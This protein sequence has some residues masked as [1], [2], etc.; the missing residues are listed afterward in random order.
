MKRSN[1]ALLSHVLVGFAALSF[2]FS[3]FLKGFFL[4]GIWLIVPLSAYIFWAIRDFRSGINLMLILL[5]AYCIIGGIREQNPWLLALTMIAAVSAWNIGG[6]TE[7]LKP[8]ETISHEA[9]LVRN[10][11]LLNGI[12]G[13]L[14]LLALLIS[15][16]I[17]LTLNIWVALILAGFIAFGLITT[18]RYLQESDL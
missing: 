4:G 12:I 6:F 1:L 15:Q 11:L 8:F 17:N 10:Q 13:G 9:V 18:I 3:M 14:T 2:L 16:T 7:R 5:A